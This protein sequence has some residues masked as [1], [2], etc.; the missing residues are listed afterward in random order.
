[1]APPADLKRLLSADP[2][3]AMRRYTVRFAH[4]IPCLSDMAPPAD[5][6]RLLSASPQ[7]AMRRYTV[8]FAH[9]I[10]QFNIVNKQ[11]P[12]K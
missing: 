6:K 3:K 1:M 12:G 4:S 10:P 5:L 7:K 8:R 11:E 2:Q 9:S